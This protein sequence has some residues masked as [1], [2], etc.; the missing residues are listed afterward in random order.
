[1]KQ[2]AQRATRTYDH[3]AILWDAW[4]IARQAS[5]R[6]GFSA[7]SFIAEAMRQAWAKAKAKALNTGTGDAKTLFFICIDEKTGFNTRA[8]NL[9]LI[10]EVFTDRQQAEAALA[11]LRG[12]FDRPFIKTSPYYRLH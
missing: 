5:R 12:A 4:R 7:H 3:R 11:V 2:I 1:M 10:D 6:F 8:V 9:S